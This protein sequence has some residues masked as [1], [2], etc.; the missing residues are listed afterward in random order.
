MMGTRFGQVVTAMVTPFDDDLALDVD[1][2]VTLARWLVAH[3]SDG[4]VLAGSTGE[5]TSLTDEEKADLWRSVAAAVTVPVLAGTG[6]ADTAH[7]VEL[8]R[9]AVACGVAGVLVVAP[10]YARPP[11]AG[12]AA[13]FRAVAEAAGDVPV[14]IYD[15]PIRTG[16]KVATETILGLAREVPN[17]LGLKDAAADVAATARL[18]A[19]APG[20]FEVYSGDDALTL[21]LLAVG[22]VGVISVASHWAGP[23]FGEMITAFSK[24]DADGARSANARLLDS[25]AFETGDANP[26]PMPAKAAM[27]ALG[28]HVGQCRLPLGPAPDGLDQRASE[29]MANLGLMVRG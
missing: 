22:G 10:Y 19:E 20:D 5:G 18:L 6:T 26:N 9:T 1:A 14:V 3:G 28:L 8:T 21:P 15:I 13:H 12:L 23:L 17:I 24:G 2:S 29:L 4:L 27:R 25:Y 7:S 11:Q 16:R